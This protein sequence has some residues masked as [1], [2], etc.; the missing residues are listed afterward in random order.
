MSE[1]YA[2]VRSTDHLAHYGVVGMKWGVRRALARGN[3]KAL[4]RNFRRAARKLR[5]LTDIGTNSKKY[6]A[7]AA[8]YGLAAA[9]TGTVAVMGTKGYANLLKNKAA[10][11]MGNAVSSELSGSKTKSL[12]VKKSGEHIFTT[13]AAKKLAEKSKQLENKA[14]KIEAWGEH[15]KATPTYEITSRAQMN[16]HKKGYGGTEYRIQQGPTKYGMSRNDKI[17]IGAAVAT[18]G[19]AAKAAQ[20]AYRAKNAAKYRKKALEYKN[21][22]DEV[23]SGTKYAGQYVAAPRRKK[24]ARR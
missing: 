22:M 19:L 20:N 5:K 6:A 7:K 12:I 17:R 23:F 3:E 24:K 11:I 2:V 9:G 10:K 1:Y 13:E 4:D 15:R 8:A 14:S 16:P 18:A 21:A